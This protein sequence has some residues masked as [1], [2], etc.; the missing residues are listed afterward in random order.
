MKKAMMTSQL[1][2]AGFGVYAEKAYSGFKQCVNVYF[3][4]EESDEGCEPAFVLNYDSKDSWIIMN[5]Y[6]TT[7]S[8]GF[9]CSTEEI[10][11]ELIIWKNVYMR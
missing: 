2:K 11:E 6:G 5:C 4:K 10:I 1:R 3:N 9:R 8:S 7:E